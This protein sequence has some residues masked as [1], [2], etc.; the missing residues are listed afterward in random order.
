MLGNVTFTPDFN[1]SGIVAITY[2]VKDN[3][4]LVSNVANITVTVTWANSPPVAVDDIL[5][6]DEDTPV[7]A[8]LLTNDYDL[9]VAYGNSGII[10]VASVDLNPLL[11]GI[12]TT[13]TITGEGSY[14]VTNTGVLTF[15]P[16]LNYNGFTTPI[17]YVIKDL[18]GAL[19]DSATIYITVNA[20]NDAPVA[21]NDTLYVSE[22]TASNTGLIDLLLNDTDVDEIK[23]SDGTTYHDERF[24]KPLRILNKY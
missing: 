8:N 21:I 1:Y 7:S 24:T 17:G 16:V 23:Y 3:A 12:Q 13:R 20:K 9:D 22:T 5:E 15:T 14:S 19:S 6:T 10:N 4:N 11:T 2:T 18:T